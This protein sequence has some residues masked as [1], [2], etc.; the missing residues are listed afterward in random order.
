M[1][2]GDD[3]ERWIV[4]GDAVAVVVTVA[5]AMV[6]LALALVLVLRRYV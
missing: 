2:A 3:G 1:I 6:V 5:V 4:V